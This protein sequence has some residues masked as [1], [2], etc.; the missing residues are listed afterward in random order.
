MSPLK[1]LVLKYFLLPLWSTTTGIL[2]D[3]WS[4]SSSL[5]YQ[6][7]PRHW[8]RSLRVTLLWRLFFYTYLLSI[9]LRFIIGVY[10]RS[11][12]D[13]QQSPLWQYDVNTYVQLYI[14]KTINF[15]SVILT[16]PL[17]FFV[18]YFDYLTSLKQFN[19]LISIPYAHM[20]LDTASFWTLNPALKPKLDP[21]KPGESLGEVGRLLRCI[22]SPSKQLKLARFQR[23]KS[24]FLPPD[25]TRKDRAQV[26]LFT[27][28]LQA[29]FAYIQ[30]LLGK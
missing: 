24:P 23:A 30:G 13:G 20:I 26:V 8:T 18:L 29:F 9:D 21:A 27:L 7:A 25:A 2:E 17:Y 3:M 19:N 11:F 12:P 28:A 22:W 6:V 4:R 10:L 1:G 14:A 15:L 16:T 5:R